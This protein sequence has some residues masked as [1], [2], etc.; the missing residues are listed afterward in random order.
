MGKKG[1]PA[2]LRSYNEYD[3]MIYSIFLGSRL[4]SDTLEYLSDSLAI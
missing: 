3:C 4:G 1:Y 2:G